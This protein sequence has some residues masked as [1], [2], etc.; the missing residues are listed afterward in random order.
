MTE[1]QLRA[2]VA[3]ADSGGFG[4]AARRLHMSQPGVSRAVRA[5][6]VEL[7]GD[8]FLRGR[9]VADLT[10]LGERVLVRS[11]AIIGEA[12]AMRQERNEARGIAGGHIRLGSMPSVSA[13][14]LPALLSRLERRHPALSVTVLDGHDDELVAWVR[15]ATVDLAVVAGEHDGLELQPL[16]TDELLAVVPAAHPLAA[17]TAV[18]AREL[19]DEPFILTRAGCERLVLAALGTQGVTPNISH[20]V[21]EASSILAMV[22]EGLGVSVMPGLAAPTP[23]ATVALR[24]LQP[25]A[26]RR[27]SLAVAPNHAP[28]PAARAFLAEAATTSASP[29]PS[30]GTADRT[31]RVL[32]KAPIRSRSA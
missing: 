2:F 18:R 6:E 12:D 16:V 20:E 17:R 23:P 22:G 30:A 28:S 3:V 14:I 15:A 27:L 10:T 4:E 19:A 29:Q 26:E 32:G 24:P 25:R 21:T 5:L 13:T 11:R 31:V 1:A 8:L 7:G 9:G